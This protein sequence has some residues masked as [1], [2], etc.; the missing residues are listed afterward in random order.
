[1]AR[2]SVSASSRSSRG[3][4]TPLAPL[5]ALALRF[6]TRV[7]RAR[8]QLGWSLVLVGLVAAALLA[9]QGTGLTRLGG[10][11]LLLSG[12][13]ALVFAVMQ[14][15]RTLADRRR[16]IAATLAQAEPMLGARA[17]RALSLVE[18]AGSSG[19]A[20]TG[21]SPELAQLH[22]Q[23]VLALAPAQHLDKWAAR[24]ADR[25]RLLLLAL[26]VAVGT[27]IAFDPARIPE[28]L[29]VLVARGGRAPFAMSWLGSLR[30]E[31]LAPA[32][33]RLP[34]RTLFPSGVSHEPTGSVITFQGVPERE[35]RQLVL[36][37]G[38]REVPFVSD[39]SGGM[40]ARW[41]LTQPASLRVAAR[42]GK[43][44]I[45]E[46]EALELR[47]VADQPPEVELEGAPSRMLLKD[48]QA[49]E[50]RYSARDDYGLREVAL[51]LRAGGREDRRT[52][53]RLDGEAKEHRGA[54]ALSPRDAF[55]RRSFLPIE[56]SVEARDNDGVSGA[57]WGKSQY[58]TLVPPG[59]GEGEEQRYLALRGAREA[60]LR[61]YAQAL[62]SVEATSKPGAEV[63]SAE[64]MRKQQ[65]ELVRTSLEPLRSF[66]D[67]TFAGLGVP[68]S[69]KT[70]LLGQSRALERPAPTP[71]TFVRR[72][73]DVLLAVDAALRATGESDATRVS[74]RLGDVAEEVA[75]AAKAGQD[76]EKRKPAKLRLGEAMTVLARGADALS[77]LSVLGA[78]L[79]GVAQGEIRRIERA[80]GAQS[81]LEAE[82]AA[83]HLAARLRRPKPSFSSADSGGV[84]AGGQRG[85]GGVS[86]PGE[87]SQAHQRFQEL[88][89]DLQQLAAEHAGEIGAVEGVL[90]SAQELEEDPEMQR[91]AKER[92]EAL[93]R[94]LSGLPDYA[95]GQT[96]AEQAAALGREH[97]R[98]MAESLS[99]LSLKD[100]ERSAKS[101]QQRLSGA[102]QT[103][104]DSSVSPE[105]MARAEQ[106]IAKQLAWVEEMLEQARQRTEARDRQALERSA[107]REQE[108]AERAQNLSGRGSH[109]EA[110]LSGEDAEALERAES[111]M[112]D[113][114]REL[115]SGRGENGLD[116]QRQAQ[117]LLDR[118]DDEERPEEP[119]PDP[120]GDLD[121]SSDRG[122]SGGP[123]EVPGRDKNQRA[124][125]FR[126]RV[127]EGLSKDQG[128]KLRPAVKRYAEGLLK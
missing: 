95:A 8:R 25:T 3:A 42:F 16:L 15:R 46:P 49:L 93:R 48:L 13:S 74:K 5:D 33:L 38:D 121:D 110:A 94:A 43:V 54:Q 86:Q 35:G 34:D 47:P 23:R 79:G 108:L 55:L 26:V 111:L 113:A 10:A 81:F 52:L 82:L 4:P 102:R 83:R 98:A 99:R 27:T 127:L 89:R 90:Q 123:V 112:R 20:E 105:D 40:L 107:K 84:E 36:V 17:L 71:V 128:G 44:L 88:M 109:G 14:T 45:L 2:A 29:D 64:A 116:L 76:L 67:G 92:A 1:M 59:V 66:V 87:A 11:L 80:L 37:G 53:E 22:F 122:Q 77:S 119:E 65:A 9:R 57:K 12:V 85:R 97:G 100:A 58:I 114:A 70:F 28:G 18:R 31:S 96:P 24:A 104:G 124:E 63:A 106:E 103:A 6:R 51:V 56:V 73:E 75:E 60:L 30:V 39:G 120:H 62:A 72:L 7:A 19:A 118:Q 126:K 91:E 41:T 69:L 101:A 117:R 78:D 125:E 115:S 32:Y 68:K 50:L 21:E 61:G